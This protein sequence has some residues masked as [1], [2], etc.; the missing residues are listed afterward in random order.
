L[1]KWIDPNTAAKLVILTPKEVLP[2][3]ESSID[4]TNIPTIYGGKFEFQHGMLPKV[5]TG[6]REALKWT[7]SQMECLPS[8]PIK[9]IRDQQGKETAVAIGQSDGEVRHQTLGSLSQ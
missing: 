3:L 1:K 6:I 9:W 5:D 8:G 2:A 7:D 4:L